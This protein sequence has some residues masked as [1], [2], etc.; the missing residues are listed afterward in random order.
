MLP[1]L[2]LHHLRKTP[3]STC[4][5]ISSTF[6]GGATPSSPVAPPLRKQLLFSE[7]SERV[8]R[9]KYRSRCLGLIAR[10]KLLALRLSRSSKMP[11]QWANS[12]LSRIRATTYINVILKTTSAVLAGL[13]AHGAATENCPNGLWLAAAL[14]CGGSGLGLLWLVSGQL[15]RFGASFDVASFLQKTLVLLLG[16]HY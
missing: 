1:G 3:Q 5:I 10:T 11:A 12:A 2:S 7:F 6:S 13:A 16:D 15:S 9:R 14:T 4:E 8:A